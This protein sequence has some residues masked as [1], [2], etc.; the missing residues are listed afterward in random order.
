MDVQ[1]PR[2]SA[3]DADGSRGVYCGKE[4][5]Q[6][7]KQAASE[8]KSKLHSRQYQA[9]SEGLFHMTSRDAPGAKSSG[10]AVI[11]KVYYFGAIGHLGW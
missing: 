4:R 1:L 2:T 11:G 9:T 7:G 8:S 6:R 10:I 3:P 5:N